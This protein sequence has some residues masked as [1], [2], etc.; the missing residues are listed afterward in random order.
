MTLRAAIEEAN[1]GDEVAALPFVASLTL[2][3]SQAFSVII[4]SGVER[5]RTAAPTRSRKN[6]LKNRFNFVLLDGGF[7]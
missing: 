6:R 2:S 3:A 4:N 1:D 7:P 5:E